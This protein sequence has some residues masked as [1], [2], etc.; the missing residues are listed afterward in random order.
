MERVKFAFAR[1]AEVE[2]GGRPW[3]Q[4]SR[5]VRGWRGREARRDMSE[6]VTVVVWR[7]RWGGGWRREGREVP[8][9]RA[10][11]RRLSMA[12][13]GRRVRSMKGEVRWCRVGVS[14]EV[15]EIGDSRP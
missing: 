2:R 11:A 5:R 4:R 12:G 15:A 7:G 10:A 1:R 8:L 6:G 14:E 3:A 9:C 13:T